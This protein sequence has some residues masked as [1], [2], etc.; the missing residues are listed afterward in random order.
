MEYPQL[1]CPYCA[2]QFS[3]A[4]GAEIRTAT[5]PHCEREVTVPA[6]APPPPPSPSLPSAPP[7]PTTAATNPPSEQPP[8]KASPPEPPPARRLSPQELAR[9]RRRVNFALAAVGMT[10]L[11]VVLL[12]LVRLRP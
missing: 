3:A 7:T 2:G 1:A 4:A 12:L 9:L 11:A 10:I 8:I 6:V 5:C